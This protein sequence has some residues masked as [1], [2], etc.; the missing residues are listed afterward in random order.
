LLKRYIILFLVAGLLLRI[1]YVYYQIGKDTTEGVGQGPSIFYGR[2][3][4]IRKGTHLGNIRLT[5]RLHRLSYRQVTGKPTIPGTFSAQNSRMSIF[6][7]NIITGKRSDEK[8]P[9]DIMMR[10]ARVVSISSAN[11]KHLDAIRLEPEEITRTIGPTMEFQKPVA[12]SGISSYVQN[13]VIAAEDARFYFHMGIDL[14]GMVPAWLINHQE[15]QFAQDNP[16]ITQ[17]L[18]KNFFLPPEKTFLRKLREVELTILLELRYSKKQILEMYLNRVYFGQNG[19]RGIYGIKEAARFF[20]SKQAKNLSLEESAL[21]AGMIHSPDR[22]KNLKAAK[23]RRN[24]VLSRMQNLKMIGGDQFQEASNSPVVI[25]PLKAPERISYFIDLI[26]RITK[27]EMGNEKFYH[28][29]YRYYTTMDPVLQALA[30]DAVSRGIEE[31]EARAFPANEKLQA[32]LVAVDPFTGETTAMVG[33][34][35]YRQAPFNRAVDAH[36][37]PG[38]AFKP[39]VLLTA[40]SQSLQGKKDLTLSSLISGEP[41]SISTPEG[42]WTPTNFENK[43]YENITIRKSIEDSVNTATTRLA[44]KTGFKNV[45]KTARLAGITSPLS[46]VPSM[47]LGSFEVT[48]RELAYAYTTMASGGIRFEPFS[49]YS[50]STE[51][52]GIIISRKIQP[53]QVFDPRVTYLAGYALEGVLERGTAI[54]AKYLGLDFPASGKTGTTN[55]NKDSW[56]VGYTPDL[57]CAVWVGYDSGTD[58]GLTGAQG[59]LHIW[60]RFMKSVYSQSKPLAFIPPKGIEIAVIDPKT[61]ELATSACPQKF[62]EAYLTGTTPGKTCHKHPVKS[63]ATKNRTKKSRV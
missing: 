52:G 37:Q 33:G 24:A 40:L 30:E 18:A 59:A 31:I 16:T 55:G 44:Q 13:A 62:T 5:E 39:F 21:L 1:G 43:T 53:E 56:F 36:R 46:P 20:F 38:S 32:A 35:D 2:P 25:K 42:L 10:D 23:E 26:Q 45:L 22:Y 19:L 12:L 54:E 7:N 6:L 8:G 4:E 9:V 3:L 57:V 27:E 50:V 41:I 17:Q 63:D 34:R 48:P 58:T 28:G 29:G 60:T 51:N 61:G 49:L 15:R 11:G 47:A 14:L